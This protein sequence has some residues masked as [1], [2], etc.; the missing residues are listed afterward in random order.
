MRLARLALATVIAEVQRLLL[1]LDEDAG[2]DIA[3]VGAA[4]LLL[5]DLEDVG[6][7]LDAG[8]KVLAVI[9]VE[10]LRQRLDAPTIIRRSSWPPSA[11]TASIRS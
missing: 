3:V 5:L 6:G 4:V 7:A 2:I 10:E 9:G 8:E 1:A 11:K